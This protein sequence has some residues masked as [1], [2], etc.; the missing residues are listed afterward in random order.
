MDKLKQEAAV[1][2]EENRVHILKCNNKV[3]W[4]IRLA[5]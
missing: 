4:S 3:R 2:R 5:H 1:F